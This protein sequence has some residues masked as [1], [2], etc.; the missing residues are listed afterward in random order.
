VRARGNDVGMREP[1]AV[2]A[3]CKRDD[4]RETVCTSYNNCRADTLL[5][6]SFCIGQVNKPDIAVLHRSVL[7]RF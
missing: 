1:G 6:M 3:A 7:Q 4:E 2:H 5:F